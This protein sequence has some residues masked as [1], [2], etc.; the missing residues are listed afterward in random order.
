[1]IGLDG[2]TDERVRKER[3]KFAFPS[4]GM[5]VRFD[6]RLPRG[7]SK[8]LAAPLLPPV[9]CRLE[10]THNQSELFVQHSFQSK[11]QIMTAMI[12]RSIPIA[13]DDRSYADRTSC[14]I[15][16]EWRRIILRCSSITSST[17]SNDSIVRKRGQTNSVF[18]LKDPDGVRGSHGSGIPRTLRT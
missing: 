4:Q 1:M 5:H 18:C 2:R 6:A 16:I 7:S 14:S 12:G 9:F 8:S 17:S 10:R 15:V 11:I 3:Q 13:D